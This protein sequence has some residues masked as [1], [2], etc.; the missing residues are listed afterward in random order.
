M[1][2]NGKEV[3]MQLVVRLHEEEA[4][5]HSKKIRKCLNNY[6]YSERSNEQRKKL[7]KNMKESQIY[8][9]SKGAPVKV[10]KVVDIYTGAETIV[11]T[12]KGLAEFLGYKRY[13]YSLWPGQINLLN[14]SKTTMYEIYEIEGE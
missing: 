9:L 7:S 2:I 5:G 14:K 13:N 10:F 12:P 3:D 1:K 6:W 8:K 4:M 11:K